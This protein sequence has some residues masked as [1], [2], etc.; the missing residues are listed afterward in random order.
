MYPYSEGQLHAKV[1]IIA[2]A[3]QQVENMME[4]ANENVLYIED[5]SSRIAALREIKV[6]CYESTQTY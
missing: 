1:S 3:N 6:H 5:N 4:P 2:E